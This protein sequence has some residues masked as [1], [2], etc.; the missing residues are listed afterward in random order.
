MTSTV[1]LHYIHLSHDPV[2]SHDP[3][4]RKVNTLNIERIIVKTLKT[5]FNL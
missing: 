2:R 5:N 3:N 4:N 1:T